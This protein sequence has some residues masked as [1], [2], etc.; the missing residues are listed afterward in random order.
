M[1][2]TWLTIAVRRL[3]HP[4]NL[5]LAS[6]LVIVVV[7]IFGAWGLSN[8]LAERGVRAAARSVDG[9][10]GVALASQPIRA[11]DHE[12]ALVG[13]WDRQRAAAALGV[14]AQT[15]P[16]LGQTLVSD[17]LWSLLQ[18]GDGTAEELRARLPGEV[19]RGLSTGL[20]LGPNELVAF[21]GLD[22]FSS[23][24]HS[25]GSGGSSA[26]ARSGLLLAA[27]L[28]LLPASSTVFM[29]AKFDG[30]ARA[31]LLTDLRLLGARGRQLKLMAALEA[32]MVAGASVV[33]GWL[34]WF[35]VRGQL[36][37]ADFLDIAFFPDHLSLSPWN[38]A[39]VLVTIA[40]VTMLAS[41]NLIDDL[42]REPSV[43]IE[44][45]SEAGSTGWWWALAIIVA[46]VSTLH[47]A[48]FVA[49][50]LSDALLGVLEIAG[51]VLVCIGLIL[52]GPHI[53]GGV[54]RL[55]AGRR[56]TSTASLLAGRR[57][58]YEQRQAFRAAAGVV[59]IAFVFGGFASLDLRAP[60]PA[61]Q[62]ERSELQLVELNGHD[63]SELAAQLFA[64][65]LAPTAFAYRLV[66]HSSL[67][68]LA[69][70]DQLKAGLAA[71]FSSPCQPGQAF[72]T[73]E[74]LH[75]EV[76]SAIPLDGEI[77]QVGDEVE[78][79]GE[80]RIDSYRELLDGVD[81]II[82]M[83]PA[84]LE[85]VGP[86]RVTVVADGAP[87]RNALFSA[88]AAT[89][90]LAVVGTFRELAEPPDPTIDRIGS[91]GRSALVGALLLAGA[92]L[93]LAAADG[94]LRRRE[95]AA[96]LFAVGTPR[97]VRVRM[98]AAEVG[99]PLVAAVIPSL[100]LGF[101][102]VY[103]GGK[104]IGG[105]VRLPVTDLLTAVV[106]VLV[107]VLLSILVTMLFVSRLPT[108]AILQ[109]EK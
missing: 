58:E 15:L 81:A 28:L 22:K 38:I 32:T 33:V 40:V 36:A 34:L 98:V 102:M 107:V 109:A 57:L 12:F 20:L 51:L 69:T 6:A 82:P 60:S 55:L 31:R 41:M 43:E 72:R 62:A 54:G 27:T 68:A 76:G 3:A 24:E 104:I 64:Q 65:G 91:M 70:C 21:A 79:K 85:A 99:I 14:S 96:L 97:S 10:D 45:G 89:A 50:G 16:S 103:V 92:A 95:T 11:D 53:L 90:P 67:V 106:A 26:G 48:V 5:V 37:N 78:I 66:E 1:I 8:G 29:A 25:H 61:V 94:A 93:A 75:R 56:G 88:V 23:P 19:N 2:R 101:E 100:L 71:E 52:L 83:E 84:H 86:T 35:V 4:Y 13:V 108:T 80:I 105:D 87:E 39:G 44:T 77:P 46:G 30:R 49:E 63:G 9:P 73:P 42:I 74:A 59:V 47:G 7:V 17:E 18:A